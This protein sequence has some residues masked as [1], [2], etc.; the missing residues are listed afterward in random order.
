MNMQVRVKANVKWGDKFYL[1]GDILDMS[2]L[3]D[4]QF[5]EE[6]GNER[7]SAEKDAVSE[8][9]PRKKRRKLAK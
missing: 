9:K 3:A 7:G 1:K 4:E 8:E 5:F 6:V 2:Y